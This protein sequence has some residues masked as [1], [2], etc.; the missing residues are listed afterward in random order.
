MKRNKSKPSMTRMSALW[1]SALVV[2]ITSPI[3]VTAD[4]SLGLKLG[5]NCEVGNYPTADSD[6]LQ[7]LYKMWKKKDLEEDDC[8]DA[9]QQLSASVG[10]AA[11]SGSITAVSGGTTQ[12]TAPTTATAAADPTADSDGDGDP[13]KDEPEDEKLVANLP[14]LSYGIIGE[15]VITYDLAEKGSATDTKNT[16]S[17]GRESASTSEKTNTSTYT[18]QISASTTASFSPLDFGVEASVGYSHT[19]E[20]SY[21]NTDIKESRDKYEDVQEKTASQ[22]AVIKGGSIAISVEIKNEGTAQIGV[23]DFRVAARR[24]TGSGANQFKD[25]ATL[26]PPTA[27]GSFKRDLAPGEK[28][29][30]QVSAKIENIALIEDLLAAPESLYFEV[31]RPELNLPSDGTEAA[32]QRSFANRI[33]AVQK[34]TVQINIDYGRGYTRA[35]YVAVDREKGNTFAEVMKILK[36]KYATDGDR[37]IALCKIRGSK[38]CPASDLLKTD[39]AQG[40]HWGGRFPKNNRSEQVEIAPEGKFEA[41]VLR[42]G[43]TVLLAFIE[44]RD[45]D[46]LPRNDEVRYKTVDDLK[47]C[48]AAAGCKDPKDFDGDG[49]TDFDEARTGWQLGTANKAQVFSAPSLADADNDGWNDKTEMAKQ[50]DPNSADTDGDKLAEGEGNQKD[51]NPLVP[52]AASVAVAPSTPQASYYADLEDLSEEFLKPN[53]LVRFGSAYLTGGSTSM[54]SQYDKYA[55]W[56]GIDGDAVLLPDAEGLAITNKGA[57]EWW[58]LSYKKPQEIRTLILWNRLTKEARQN[59]QQLELHVYLNGKDAIPA[60]PLWDAASYIADDRRILVISLP[61]GVKADTLELK[62]KPGKTAEVAINEFEVYGPPPAAVPPLKGRY[63]IEVANS[64]GEKGLIA[65]WGA[66]GGLVSGGN[67][68]QVF[69]GKAEDCKEECIFTI[70]PI[71]DWNQ[72]EST[73]SLEMVNAKGQKGSIAAWGSHEGVSHLGHPL[74]MNTTAA[75]CNLKYRCEFMIVPL[76]GKS[77]TYRIMIRSGRSHQLIAAVIAGS[78]SQGLKH[79]GNAL[80]VAG[81]GAYNTCT[82]NEC[83][84][85]LTPV[86]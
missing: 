61:P 48:T 2:G 12:P 63:R 38:D 7:T 21:A 16:V 56:R 44:D 51:P 24:R 75:D 60:I 3:L 15:T 33:T 30:V 5:N 81:N 73:Y 9:A 64:K 50:T 27:T 59:V 67:P 85:I 57:N 58:R 55:A 77:N 86:P 25:V 45:K 68:L 74:K 80:N 28:M 43:D 72:R 66:N 39:E 84:F 40:M 32:L 78:A 13:D 29:N 19:W 46:G 36:L 31:I 52:D 70:N 37:L 65:A 62:P 20:N 26:A 4:K 79:G 71:A 17:L 41:T 18:N 35:Y 22:N 76:A 10:K 14:F 82:P 69:M 34:K 42:A 11:A 54:S 83:D 8:K 49:I 1:L 6:L 53:K 47:D 23:G